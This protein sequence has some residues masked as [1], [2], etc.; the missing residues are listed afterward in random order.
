MRYPKAIVFDYK[1]F[2]KFATSLVKEA[3]DI[4]DNED[5]VDDTSI[6]SAWY[7][8]EISKALEEL[9]EKEIEDA[10]AREIIVLGSKTS[11]RGGCNRIRSGIEFAKV[12]DRYFGIEKLLN[13]KTPLKYKEDIAVLLEDNTFH[14]FVVEVLTQ[15][16][17]EGIDVT[18]LNTVSDVVEEKL[19]EAEGA[20]KSIVIV[21]GKCL[22]ESI[23]DLSIFS[24]ADIIIKEVGLEDL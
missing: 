6:K 4:V 20:D 19:K 12:L 1:N 9:Y 7:K 10:D 22:A 16:A 18:L 24:T 8:K 21:N 14:K 23:W 3:Q 17:E 11:I 15:V 13:A 5:E 2:E